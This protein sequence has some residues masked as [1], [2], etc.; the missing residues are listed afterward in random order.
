MAIKTYKPVT[1]GSRHK[2]LLT[3]DL[4]TKDTPEKAL[5][6]K[7]TK[8]GG[9][10]NQGYI[11]TRHHGGGH[12]Q[13]YRI[14]DFK[15]SIENVPGIVK[16]IEYDPNRNA[17]IALVV[18]ENGVK[19]Y[20][21]APKGLEVGQR[22]YSGANVEFNVGN[23]LPLEKIPEGFFVHNVELQPGKG[24]QL[25]RAAGTS[26]QVLGKEG[27]Y[28]SL[29]LAS[30]EVRKI[31]LSCKATIGVV[32]NEEQNLVHLGKAGRTRWLG[33]RPTVRGSAMNPNDHPH[34]G[35]EGKCPVGRDAPRTPWG[36]RALGVK[37]R[38]VKKASTNLIIR[39]RNGK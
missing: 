5:L 34:G 25:C 10:N 29:R 20:I 17:L 36:K 2:Q 15:R 22:I 4:I 30:G 23:C 39:R 33:I 28:A 6:A 26:A 9:R 1:P 8:K 13:K 7:K 31:L 32:G 27:K 37:T 14:I 19:T 21:I 11:T 3:S 24:G 18:Y 16:A 35:G 38:N 12:K